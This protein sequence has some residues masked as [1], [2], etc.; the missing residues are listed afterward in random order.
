MEQYIAARYDEEVH[1]TS[2]R[3]IRARNTKLQTESKRVKFFDFKGLMAPV[4]TAFKNNEEQSLEVQ[5]ID[6]YAEWLK[7]NRISG[8]LVNGMSGEGPALGLS[9]RMR[10]AEAWWEAAQKYEL[11]MFL[12]VG[13][14][15]L[16]DV[17]VMADHAHDLGVHAV[18]CLPELFYKPTT[19]EQLVSY[20]R[21]VARRCAALPFFYYHLPLSTGVYLNMRDFCKLAEETIPNFYGIHFASND[22][23]D[24]EACLREGRV[25]IL[26]NS[27]LL[28]CGLL[29]GFESAL[30]TVLNI[31]PDLGWAIW[32][33]MLNNNLETAR[34][35]QM[36]LN[37]KISYYMGRSNEHGYIEAM[38]QWF[39]DE[40]RQ[41]N[42]P[43][44]F[45]GS[46]RKFF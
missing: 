37:N 39:D 35:T 28:A 19:I 8:V 46:A 16:P 26:G 14:A 12:Q 32:N 34:D 23:D 9:E 40:V 13:G 29:V 36:L 42:G 41:G 44:F 11:V 6:R 7:S 10:N 15:P 5:H 22:L 18:L 43:G 20:M 27:R 24:G 2:M 17:L 38:K 33:A 21:L 4:F 3:A 30:M 1:A 25:I 45:I 31:R